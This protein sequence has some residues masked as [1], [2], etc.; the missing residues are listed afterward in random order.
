M[1]IANTEVLGQWVRDK[2][3]R[4]GVTQREL[5]MAAGTGLR[6]II[7]LEKGKETCQIGKVFQV[8]EA[9]G[10]QMEVNPK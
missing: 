3:K 5:S 4:I 1:K 7:D 9:L 2:R 6:W 8:L 10:T